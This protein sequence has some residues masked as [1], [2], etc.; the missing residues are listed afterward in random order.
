MTSLLI[1]R[2]ISPK[3]GLRIYVAFYTSLQRA[4]LEHN[5]ECTCKIPSDIHA[6]G[7]AATSNMQQHD[8]NSR[9]TID[10]I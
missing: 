7:T 1:R 10:S 2:L 6:K 3:V 4:N 9:N 5:P 8:A